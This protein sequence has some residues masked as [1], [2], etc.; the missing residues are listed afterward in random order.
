MLLNSTTRNSVSLVGVA[1]SC[2]LVPAAAMSH[3]LALAKRR[4]DGRRGMRCRTAKSQPISRRNGGSPQGA[5]RDTP[6]AD[7]AFWREPGAIAAMPEG[8]VP[9]V[10][11]SR[12]VLWAALVLAG[13]YRRS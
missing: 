9:A 7:K 2:G 6:H 12:P 8:Q 10:S 4:F 5:R 11:Q 3:R 1:D 13:R